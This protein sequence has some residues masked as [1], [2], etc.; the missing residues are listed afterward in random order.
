MY[1]LDDHKVYGL[2]R[3]PATP[4]FAVVRTVQEVQLFLHGSGAL[5]FKHLEE[6]TG[7]QHIQRLQDH[8]VAPWTVVSGQ[9]P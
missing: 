4:S 1:I 6:L 7:V 5:S 9:T 2:F 8:S 3:S